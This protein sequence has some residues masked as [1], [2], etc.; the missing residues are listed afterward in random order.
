MES[1][2]AGRWPVPGLVMRRTLPPAQ[3]RCPA[4]ASPQPVRS[5]AR[6]RSRSRICPRVRDCCPIV[7]PTDAPDAPP[8]GTAPQRD[9]N[10]RPSSPVGSARHVDAGNRGGIA[11]R[12]GGTPAPSRG[13]HC[14]TT[15]RPPRAGSAARASSRAMPTARRWR[16]TCRA[17]W[18]APATRSRPAGC[19]APGSRRAR[20]R[21]SRWPPPR[22]ASSST[23]LEVRA[24]QPL[25]HARPARHGGRR[26]ARRCPP[27]RATCNCTSGSPRTASSPRACAR[28]SK[29]AIAARPFRTRWSNAVPVDLR[30]D[31]GAG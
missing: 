12:G 28:W 31:V 7:R 4:R 3:R 10:R 9:Q 17:N 16:P 19:S 25:G 27:D 11:A 22:R 8:L 29:T 2:S 23:T 26:T 24:T 5:S 30:I 18:A 15:R 21:A 14:T 1:C 20:R 13:G 6:R